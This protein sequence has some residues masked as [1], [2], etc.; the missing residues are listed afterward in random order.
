MRI[1]LALT[2]AL[3]LINGCSGSN[4][5]APKEEIE[6][7]SQKPL[8]LN[9]LTHTEKNVIL[10]KGTEQPYTGKFTDHFA[11]GVYTCKQCDAML[12]KSGSKFKAHCGWPAFDD[13][14]KGAVKR[15]PDADGR[16]I[17][18]VCSNCDGHLGHVFEGEKYTDKNTRHCVNSISM[19]FVHADK[20]KTERAIFAGGCFWG[21]EYYMQQAP[22]V[23]ETSVGYTGG[24]SSNPTYRD[25]CSHKTGHIEAVEIVFDPASVSFEALAKLFF[26]IHDPTEIDRQGNDRGEQ[27]RSEIFYLDTTQ[28]ETTERLI[29]ILKMKG[30][31]IATKVSP[32]KQFWKAEIK[33]QDYY[34]KT[35]KLPYCH[36]YT[37]RF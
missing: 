1:I 34:I 2:T 25:V 29:E 4:P 37:K 23:L 16:R 12:Y 3:L 32:A 21:V 11:E 24:H 5:K 26:E 17:E 27:Y 22:G 18:I 13:E 8:K 19:K 14:I 15:I 20:I 9:E 28:K 30:L 7:S 31:K 33:H 6:M 10:N 36:A 35:K